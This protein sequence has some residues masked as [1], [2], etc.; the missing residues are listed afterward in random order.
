MMKKKWITVC[1]FVAAC[2]LCAPVLAFQDGSAEMTASL[3]SSD[4]VA[5]TSRAKVPSEAYEGDSRYPQPSG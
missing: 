1:A 4:G 3:F 5:F 2:A